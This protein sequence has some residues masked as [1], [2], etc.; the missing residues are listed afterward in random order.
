[1]TW[2]LFSD[3]ELRAGARNALSYADTLPRLLAEPLCAL[4]AQ[5]LSELAR[6]RVAQGEPR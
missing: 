5:T 6:R 4:A 1:M 3:A 2:E